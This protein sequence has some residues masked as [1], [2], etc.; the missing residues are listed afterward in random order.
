LSPCFA[1]H[2][3]A[4]VFLQNAGASR[5]RNRPQRQSFSRNG[6]VEKTLPRNPDYSKTYEKTPFYPQGGIDTGI[7]TSE[8]GPGGNSIVNRF[9]SRLRW[10]NLMGCWS[11]RGM[12][13]RT[14]TNR[15]SLATFE[16]DALVF[17][18]EF[19]AEG[20]KLNLRKVTHPVSA[21]KNHQ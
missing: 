2:F 7:Y 8:L 9:H 4:A 5:K 10:A 21:G 13:K 1:W 3:R 15:T 19:A 17:R 6:A 16:G 11:L 20:M 18:S 12:R 14:P